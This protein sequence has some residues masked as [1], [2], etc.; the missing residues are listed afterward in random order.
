MN[1]VKADGLTVGELTVK[2]DASIEEEPSR[3]TFCARLGRGVL[4]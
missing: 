1:V 4:A 3:R 2:L